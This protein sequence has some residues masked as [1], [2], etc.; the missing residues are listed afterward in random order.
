MANAFRVIVTTILFLTIIRARARAIRRRRMEQIPPPPS[1]PQAHALLLSWE[2][3]DL[4]P[5]IRLETRKLSTTLTSLFNISLHPYRIPCSN[6]QRER[7][8]EIAS[9]VG[10]HPEN[11]L[12]FVY[13]AGH[14][15]M[16]RGEMIW[17][18]VST[19]RLGRICYQFWSPS[20]NI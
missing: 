13:Y 6:S 4:E 5:A 15:S 12:L 16:D 9:F 2:E 14:G 20:N 3:S 17:S 19:P 8:R 1:Q 11:S 18:G 10:T 7:E